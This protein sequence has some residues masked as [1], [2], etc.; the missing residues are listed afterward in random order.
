MSISRPQEAL[1][2][3]IE[4]AVRILKSGGVVAIPTDT[5]Y[6]LA[7]SPFNEAAVERVY[8]LKGRPTQQ[9]LPLLLAEARDI[10]LWARSIP[11][12]TW[13]LVE[14]FWPGALSL[15]LKKAK[16]VPDAVSGGTDTV[17]LRVPDHRVA[18]AISQG[19]GTPITGTSANRSGR[20]GLSTAKAVREEFGDEIDLVI[21]GGELSDGLASTVLDLSGE[22]PRVL[23]QGVVPTARDRGAVWGS[24]E[25]I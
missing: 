21:D 17:A 22:R 25:R 16:S 13:A 23:R 11:E 4:T 9:A 20:P 18:R 6:G 14:R 2:E 19:L 15:V 7:A 1:Q 3:Q 8:R 12:V 10:T 24:V 5:L